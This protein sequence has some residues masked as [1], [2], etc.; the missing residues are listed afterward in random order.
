MVLLNIKNMFNIVRNLL[1]THK[2]QCDL[3]IVKHISVMMI[4]HLVKDYVRND[5]RFLTS[6][7]KLLFWGKYWM[8]IYYSRSLKIDVNNEV[9]IPSHRYGN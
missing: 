2:K 7:F 1:I 8:Y 4:D 5:I 9:K 3:A 6:D